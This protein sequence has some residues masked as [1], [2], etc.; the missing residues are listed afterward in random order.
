MKT[1]FVTHVALNKKGEKVGFLVCCAG[2]LAPFAEAE[3]I[4]S[5]K[6]DTANRF[7]DVD[8]SQMTVKEW[9]AIQKAMNGAIR[10]YRAT[11]IGEAKE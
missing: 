9:K 11:I 6:H 8:F 10:F 5:F 2:K 7:L 3:T 4:D 1:R